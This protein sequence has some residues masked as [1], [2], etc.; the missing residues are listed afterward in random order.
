VRLVARGDGDV[1]HGL[2]VVDRDQVD[3]ADRPARLADRAGHPAEHSG[4][5]LDLHADRERVLG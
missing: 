3:G 1:A 5:V 4:L 2:V